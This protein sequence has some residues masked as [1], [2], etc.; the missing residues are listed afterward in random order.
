M[1]NLK[2]S[3]AP[4]ASRVKVPVFSTK[5]KPLKGSRVRNTRYGETNNDVGSRKAYSV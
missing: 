5:L 1:S 2:T 4:N 3:S